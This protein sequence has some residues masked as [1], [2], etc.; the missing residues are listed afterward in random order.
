MIPVW[1]SRPDWISGSGFMCS[2]GCREE[3]VTW[4]STVSL[5]E[6]QKTKVCSFG[7]LHVTSAHFRQFHHTEHLRFP[8]DFSQITVKVPNSDSEKLWVLTFY[9]EWR[10]LI[11]FKTLSVFVCVK[12][13]LWLNLCLCITQCVYVYFKKWKVRF[14][15]LPVK[16]NWFGGEILDFFCKFE[17]FLCSTKHLCEIVFL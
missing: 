2:S 12:S 14:C 6:S 8:L 13:D 9:L 16:I 5:C 1:E 10:I 3:T 17:Y 11:C 15:F 7:S 4:S